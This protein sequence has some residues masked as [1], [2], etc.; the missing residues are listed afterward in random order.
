MVKGLGRVFVIVYVLKW[1]PELKWRDWSR[2]LEN[3]LLCRLYSWTFASGFENFSQT[4]I[5]FKCSS[6]IVSLPCSSL[7]PLYGA[8]HIHFPP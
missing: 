5:F 2:S 4:P 8:A 1:M 7:Y 6:E 3:V